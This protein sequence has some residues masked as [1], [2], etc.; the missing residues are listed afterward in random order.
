MICKKQKLNF[1]P[2]GESLI[3]EIPWL[4]DYKIPLPVLPDN[5]TAA[6][7]LPLYV[8]L[9][10]DD[11]KITRTIISKPTPCNL[12]FKGIPFADQEKMKNIFLIGMCNIARYNV[13]AP[14]Q[15]EMNLDEMF[16]ILGRLCADAEKGWWTWHEYLQRDIFTFLVFELMSSDLMMGN[17]ACGAKS[18]LHSASPCR[19]CAVPANLLDDPSFNITLVKK[20]P[21]LIDQ[22]R[23]IASMVFI[24]F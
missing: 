24:I 2:L 18:V 17:P 22:I 3:K 1:Q 23:L 15:N 19:N 14:M 11:F 12:I 10:A 16:L 13:I 20:T 8:E 9:N 21:Q 6:Q 5:I 4:P 7:I